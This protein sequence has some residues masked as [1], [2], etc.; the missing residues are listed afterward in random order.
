MAA[1]DEGVEDVQDGVAAPGVLVFTQEESFLAGWISAGD[2]V[3]V[4]AEGLELVDELV[5]NI[6]GPVI[7]FI[8]FGQQ[9]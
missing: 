4:T 8:A 7:L 1:L 2:T 9:L 5:D 3:A 6:P